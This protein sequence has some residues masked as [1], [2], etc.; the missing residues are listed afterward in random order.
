MVLDLSIPD[1]GLLPYFDGSA[2]SIRLYTESLTNEACIG[3]TIY[4][5]FLEVNRQVSIINWQIS[6]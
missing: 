2:D 5:I 3:G 1:L 4:P 6:P